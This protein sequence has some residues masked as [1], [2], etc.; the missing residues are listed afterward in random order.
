MPQ[1]E[2][3]LLLA[4]GPV[5][6]PKAYAPNYALSLCLCFCLHKPI[7]RVEGS[8]FI[9]GPHAAL[10]FEAPN[11]PLCPDDGAVLWTREGD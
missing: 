6:R 9:S 10:H 7:C 11:G 3:L 2:P 5:P 1:G 4:Q 8:W